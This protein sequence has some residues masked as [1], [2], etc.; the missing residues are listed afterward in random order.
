VTDVVLLLTAAFGPD[1]V[2][3][4]GGNIHNLKEM[5]SG[6]RTGDNAN[7]FAGGFRLWAKARRP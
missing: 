1:E 6:C 3:L 4:G 2:V 5:P 7:S